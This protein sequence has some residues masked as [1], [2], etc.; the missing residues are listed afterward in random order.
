MYIKYQTNSL[1]DIA[2]LD[3]L[4]QCNFIRHLFKIQLRVKLLIN[5]THLSSFIMIHILLANN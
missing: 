4:I 1:I 3:I 2:N 5:L